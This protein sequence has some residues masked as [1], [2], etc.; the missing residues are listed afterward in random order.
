MSAGVDDAYFGIADE[1]ADLQPIGKVGWIFLIFLRDINFNGL[2]RK[3]AVIFGPLGN[4]C[5]ERHPR[6]FAAFNDHTRLPEWA[7]IVL[8]HKRREP[9]LAPLFVGDSF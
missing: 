2:T 6:N 3:L 7:P 1:A 8:A 4:P 9:Y 5:F